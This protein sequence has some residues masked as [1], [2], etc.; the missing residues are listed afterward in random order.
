M[1]INEVGLGYLQLCWLFEL[2]LLCQKGYVL[3][4]SRMGQPDH[5]Y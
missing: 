1:K 2:L 5:E 3:A 4:H